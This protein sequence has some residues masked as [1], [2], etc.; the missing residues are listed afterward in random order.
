[1]ENK[2]K[3]RK[4]S[5]NVMTIGRRALCNFPECSLRSKSTG[6]KVHKLHQTLTMFIKNCF[7]EI[8]MQQGLGCQNG[9]HFSGKANTT[10]NIQLQALA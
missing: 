5:A 8:P 3:M 10:S 2:G 6:G 1:M 4:Y 7:Y 9:S